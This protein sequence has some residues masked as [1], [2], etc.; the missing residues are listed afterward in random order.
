[1]KGEL[2][3]F[4][5]NQQVKGSRQA[6]KEQQVCIEISS[7][8]HDFSFFSYYCKVV[9]LVFIA[10]VNGSASCQFGDFRFIS[11]LTHARFESI[12]PE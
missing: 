2:F 4:K 1:M 3:H 7:C 10:N 5:K 11:F 6:I 8:K 9:E 12:F